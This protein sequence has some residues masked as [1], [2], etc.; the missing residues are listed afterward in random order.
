MR[1][2]FIDALVEAAQ[3]SGLEIERL[4]LNLLAG[5]GIGGAGVGGGP[6]EAKANGQSDDKQEQ[7][8][9]AGVVPGERRFEAFCARERPADRC[10]LRASFCGVRMRVWPRGRCTVNGRRDAA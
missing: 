3:G 4:E 1:A 8:R 6:V 9:E 7:E 5:E 2:G 10:S